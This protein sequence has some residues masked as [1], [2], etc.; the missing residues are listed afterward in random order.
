MIDLSLS[1]VLLVFLG[2]FVHLSHELEFWKSY[3]SGRFVE[4]LRK[5]TLKIRHFS[6]STRKKGSLLLDGH[7]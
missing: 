7:N 2:S 6:I 5:A 1:C 4:N 3:S